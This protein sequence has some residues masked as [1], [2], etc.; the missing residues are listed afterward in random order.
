MSQQPKTNTDVDH[1]T[2]LALGIKVLISQ[3]E[4]EGD[5]HLCVSSY[6]Y[7]EIHNHYF[8]ILESAFT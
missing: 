7:R 8:T 5:Q 6:S 1:P 4:L 3:I 2:T